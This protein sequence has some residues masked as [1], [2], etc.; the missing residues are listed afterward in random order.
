MIIGPQSIMWDIRPVQACT[1]LGGLGEVMEKFTSI[2]SAS[3]MPLAAAAALISR[4]AGTAGFPAGAPSRIPS[5][6]P[7]G[8]YSIQ[9][10]ICC[11]LMTM[12]VLEDC[13]NSASSLLGAHRRHGVVFVYLLPPSY[14]MG[15]PCLQSDCSRQLG[16]KPFGQDQ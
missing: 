11:H 7:A 3:S 5:L 10:Q 6:L 8:P 9:A 4:P 13:D 15:R 16:A 12:P 14:R 1:G 2:S